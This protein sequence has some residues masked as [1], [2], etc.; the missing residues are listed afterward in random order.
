LKFGGELRYNETNGNA[1]IQSNGEFAFFGSETGLDIA[2]FFVGAPS[3][4]EQGNA[5]PF[6]MRNQYAGAF[7]EDSWRIRRT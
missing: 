5:Q 6:Y 1:D 4:Y 7:V 3:T 2:D